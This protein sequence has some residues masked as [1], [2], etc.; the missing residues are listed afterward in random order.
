MDSSGEGNNIIRVLDILPQGLITLDER[1]R[2]LH[3]NPPPSGCS[4]SHE[5]KYP[6]GSL[7]DIAGNS[8]RSSSTNSRRGTQSCGSRGIR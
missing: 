3:A 1:G 7:W 4:V 8:L 6:E 2:V 5:I